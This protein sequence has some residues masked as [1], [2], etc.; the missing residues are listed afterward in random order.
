MSIS[1]GLHELRDK[2]DEFHTDP[3]LLT[4]SDDG[5]AHTVA[6]AVAWDGDVILIGAGNT[7]RRNAGARPLVA[8][9]WPPNATGEFSLIVDADAKR[10]D[11]TQVWLEPTRAVLHR[12]APSG[13]GSDCEPV[14]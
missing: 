10:V 5:R 7:S 13:D 4:V 9:L 14:L 11:E 3:Y 1:V 6:V 2:I 12:P 8:L